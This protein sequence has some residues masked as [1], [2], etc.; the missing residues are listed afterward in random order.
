MN[1][2]SRGVLYLSLYNQLCKLVGIN[3]LIT[4]KQFFGKLGKHFLIPKRLRPVVLK[5]M[6]LMEL[7]K[8]IDRDT[9]KV[10]NCDI[11]LERDANKLYKKVGLF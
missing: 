4:R 7:I 8:K 5:E 9:I 2:S 11:D 1:E 10:L 3:R 6:E